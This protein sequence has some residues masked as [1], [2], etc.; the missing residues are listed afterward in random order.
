MNNSELPYTEDQKRGVG[1]IFLTSLILLGACI[2]TASPWIITGGF[3]M[4]L[5]LWLGIYGMMKNPRWQETLPLGTLREGLSEGITECRLYQCPYCILHWYAISTAEQ[6]LVDECM[7][8]GA[9]YLPYEVR[10][11]VMSEDQR[12]G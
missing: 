9:E 4:A 8:C 2:M 12:G 11:M 5:P 7:V 1:L 6:P 10:T 3:C